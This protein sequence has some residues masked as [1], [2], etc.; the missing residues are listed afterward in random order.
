M[1]ILAK[2][3]TKA[4]PLY[5]R[6][7]VL[8]S[9]ATAYDVI[10]WEYIRETVTLANGQN[11]NVGKTKA[12]IVGSLNPSEGRQLTTKLLQKLTEAEAAEA[13]AFW[14]AHLDQVAADTE[15]RAMEAAPDNVA[16]AVSTVLKAIEAG[17]LSDAQKLAVLATAADLLK[18]AKRATKDIKVAKSE[19]AAAIAQ[20]RL[21]VAET[22]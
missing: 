13:S 14:T 10:R 7:R 4:K 16:C 20:G 5:F 1:T 22:A 9:G 15:R 21:A 3:S 6:P 12:V 19:T 11:K 8:T 2:A 17:V 18:A